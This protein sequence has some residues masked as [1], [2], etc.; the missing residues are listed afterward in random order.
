MRMVRPAGRRVSPARRQPPA[1]QPRAASR[2]R[3]RQAASSPTRGEP[4]PPTGETVGPPRPTSKLP[5]RNCRRPSGEDILQ[6]LSREAALRLGHVFGGAY[7]FDH[8][9]VDDALGLWCAV[10]VAVAKQIGGNRPRCH[11]VDGDAVATELHGQ[12]ACHAN[13]TGFARLWNLQSLCKLS[14]GFF[15]SSTGVL[16]ASQTPGI[17]NACPPVSLPCTRR[18]CASAALC[19]APRWVPWSPRFRLLL[20]AA[21]PVLVAGTAQ[22]ATHSTVQPWLL[23]RDPP[24]HPAPPPA[25]D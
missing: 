21:M 5:R 20:H 13:Q 9:A 10:W 3:S 22:Y 24:P 17:P 7:A 4:E 15:H 23:L 16:F 8:D 11:S 19:W 25:A 14:Q 2:R 6:I 18:L 1:L 12:G